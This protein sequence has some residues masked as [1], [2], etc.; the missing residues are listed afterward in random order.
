MKILTT[1]IVLGPLVLISTL[2][3]T[4]QRIPAGTL[5]Q[6]AAGSDSTGDRDT[7]TL[8]AW[9]EMQ[10]WQRKLHTF[11]EKAEVKGKEAGNA[12]EDG[13]NAAW[14]KTQTESR[15]LQTASAEGWE[16]A[17]SSYEQASH[18]LADAWEKV[19]LQDK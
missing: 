10:E 7:Y 2:P 3:A 12:V 6:V 11:T 19:R 1:S 8:R 5:V 13:L 15:K 17:K 4:G 18:E 9:N 14:A 16:S